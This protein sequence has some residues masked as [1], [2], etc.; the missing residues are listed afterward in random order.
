VLFIPYTEENIKIA[1]SYLSVAEADSILQHQTD[2]SI[3]NSYSNETKE[4]MLIKSSVAIDGAIMYQG[5]KTDSEQ[6]LKF[7]RNGSTTIPLGIKMAVAALC[8]R[9]SNTE[10]FKNIT[11]ETISKL[12][13]TYK[14]NKN[15]LDDEIMAFL[16]PFK[17]STI[18]FEV[19]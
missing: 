1:N 6:V 3:W 15:G 18:K 9:Y 17:C 4:I 7:P 14:P 12:S 2:S 13:I 8:L 19:V 10:A 16:K 11:S 5:T